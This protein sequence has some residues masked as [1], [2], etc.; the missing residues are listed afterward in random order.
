MN[1]LVV[2]VKVHNGIGRACI[3]SIAP[4]MLSDM[5]ER[6]KV[7]LSY[8]RELVLRITA[9]DLPAMRAAAN[10]YIRWLDMCTRLVG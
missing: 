3:G 9:K 10:T 2:S 7:E 4:E 1:E 6:S 5:H 8:G